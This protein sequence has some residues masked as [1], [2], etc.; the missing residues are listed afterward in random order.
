MGYYKKGI[1]YTQIAV[2]EQDGQDGQDGQD[3][4]NKMEE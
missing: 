1:S 4:D 3:E 2:I